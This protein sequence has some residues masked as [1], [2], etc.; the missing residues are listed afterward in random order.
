VRAQEAAPPQQPLDF[1]HRDTQPVDAIVGVYHCGAAARL[2][3]ADGLGRDG[4]AVVA[5]G[6]ENPGDRPR[7]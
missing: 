6:E 5:R 7:R 1:A 4:D 3:E 2:D